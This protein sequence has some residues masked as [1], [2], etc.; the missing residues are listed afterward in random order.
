MPNFLIF[1]KCK[2]FVSPV[3]HFLH[4]LCIICKD[5]VHLISFS[6]NFLIFMPLSFRN[7]AKI[8]YQ[9]GL[10]Y[11]RKHEVPNDHSCRTVLHICV[12][13]PLTSSTVSQS[14]ARIL[15]DF[16]RHDTATKVSWGS[17]QKDK[18]STKLSLFRL[19]T[20]KLRYSSLVCTSYSTW[21]LCLVWNTISAH[22]KYIREVEVE[23]TMYCLHSIK[24]LFLFLFLLNFRPLCPDF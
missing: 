17:T 11:S 21:G 3:W 16:I 9:W 10:W 2:V 24:F 12:I 15:S 18:P 5:I 1:L 22:V 6:S 4:N 20:S 14:L 8:W 23:H 7:Q 19:G 13:Q